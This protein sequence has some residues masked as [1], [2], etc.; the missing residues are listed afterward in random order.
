MSLK[1]H[2]IKLMEDV[3]MGFQ[4][5]FDPNSGNGIT[6]FAPTPAT[7]VLKSYQVDGDF[8]RKA[9]GYGGVAQQ[10]VDQIMGAIDGQQTDG[11]P[12]GGGHFDSVL[13]G[14]GVGAD[15]GADPNAQVPPIA[16]GDV[17]PPMG[18]GAGMSPDSMPPMD[19]GG[20][21]D[22]GAEAGAID[23]VA[24]DMGAGE[25]AIGG[26]PVEPETDPAAEIGSDGGIPID[27]GAGVGTAGVG[28][29]DSVSGEAPEGV[30]PAD[31]VEDEE[32]EEVEPQ[33]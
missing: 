10:A 1:K 4:S 5:S 25:P 20:P 11:G 15:V 9:I 13:S 30:E 6:K 22:A 31:G 8:L 28:S 19:G 33:A 24:S 16:G 3:D 23:P 7:K 26:Q 14:F 17:V 2:F 12:L 21:V 18:S 27:A 32:G 29:G